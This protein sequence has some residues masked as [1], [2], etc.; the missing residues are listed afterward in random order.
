MYFK[1][2]PQI[3]YVFDIAGKGVNKIVKDITLNVRMRKQLLSNISVYDFYDMQEG[4]TPE[5]IASKIYGS[6]EYHWVI[7]LANERFDYKNDFPMDQYTLNNFIID[8]Y[9]PDED[10]WYEVHHYEDADGHVVS[11]DPDNLA[12]LVAVSN[13]DYEVRLNDAKRQIKLI[14]P[15]LLGNILKQYGDII[16]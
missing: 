7:M 3:Y 6:P 4:E 12:S 10:S 1:N 5:I 13:Y 14:H 11:Y 9:G 16:R 8:K 2:F 15:Q